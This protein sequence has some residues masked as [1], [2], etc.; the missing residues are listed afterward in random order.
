MIEPACSNGP[1]TRI[2]S[3][4]V[5]PYRIALHRPWQSARGAFGDRSGW[6]V[7]ARSER[8]TG[9]GDCAPLPEAG[10]EPLDQSAL[11]LHAWETRLVGMEIDE[12][13]SLLAGGAPAAPAAVTAVECAL[14]D[15]QS[16]L[17]G[18]SL[19]QWIARPAEADVPNSV[20]VNVVL[21]GVG[22]VGPDDV[23]RA[24]EDGFG[25]LKLKVGL[26]D[27]DLELV[28]LAEIARSLHAGVR[29]RLDAN[30]AW[31]GDTAARVVAMLNQLPVESLE[32]PLRVPDPET[33]SHLQSLA[34]FPLALDE[35]LGSLRAGLVRGH[36]PVRR[37]VL[38][39]PVIGGLRATLE[40]ARRLQEA[41]CEVVL[42]SLVE[43]AAGL[44]PTAQLAAAI[45]SPLP[46][47]LDTARWLA[48]DLGQAPIPHLGRIRLPDGPGSGFQPHA[49]HGDHA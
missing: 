33:L 3:L 34:A 49:P 1:Q 15:L 11:A 30:G 44:W 27:P 35:S 12:A 6:L 25:V 29:L 20:P 48:A 16:R 45:G 17:A 28:R 24:C 22:T 37:A 42:T 46:H 39:P 5:H 36:L 2:E 32:E 38:K 8:V 7:R 19:R 18:V 47:G 23:A 40:L 26:A 21:G 9:Y 14:L 13:L 31:D 10:T 4:S 43:T 41:G